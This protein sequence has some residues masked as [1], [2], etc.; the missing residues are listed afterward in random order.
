M[1]ALTLELVE[2]WRVDCVCVE[3]KRRFRLCI[4]SGRR[5]W[6][7]ACAERGRVSAL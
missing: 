7:F 3:L 4:R 6:V 2:G 5:S 1:G